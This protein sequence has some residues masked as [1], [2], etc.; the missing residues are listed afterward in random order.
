MCHSAAN[1]ATADSDEGAHFY[2]IFVEIKGNTD[3]RE[4]N[5]ASQQQVISQ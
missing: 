1:L 3:V 5:E 4:L 2:L